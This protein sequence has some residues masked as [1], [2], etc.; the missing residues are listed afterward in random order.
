MPSGDPALRAEVEA[1]VR[2][3]DCSV[4]HAVNVLLWS[5]IT[6]RKRQARDT[7]RNHCRSLG[8]EPLCETPTA[9]ALRDVFRQAH[10][11]REHCR[12]LGHRPVCDT[13]MACAL[14]SAQELAEAKP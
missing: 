14:L 5:A 4:A 13:M 2:A 9:C 11:W 3:W 1:I 7:W 10:P 12:R 8:H 6:M